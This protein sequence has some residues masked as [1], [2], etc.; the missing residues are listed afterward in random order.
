MGGRSLACD[1]WV[2]VDLPRTGIKKGLGAYGHTSLGVL[3]RTFMIACDY[4]FADCV[5]QTIVV[6]LQHDRSRG[7]LLL[8]PDL[9]S[10]YELLAKNWQVSLDD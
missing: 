3:G 5:Q 2:A 1:H 4:Q 7:T 6:L 9:I 8:P 10:T